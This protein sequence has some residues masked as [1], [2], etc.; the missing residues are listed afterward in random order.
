MMKK[1]RIEEIDLRDLVYSDL[2]SSSPELCVFTDCPHFDNGWKNSSSS[3]NTIT[4]YYEDSESARAYCVRPYREGV[5]IFYDKR[6]IERKG[7]WKVVML[8]EDDGFWFPQESIYNTEKKEFI[9]LITEAIS[10]FNA[11]FNENNH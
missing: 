9:Y 1:K 7:P 5:M 4:R 3:C 2:S 8:G 6:D 11:N 10:I